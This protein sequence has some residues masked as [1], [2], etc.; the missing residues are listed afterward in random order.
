VSAFEVDEVASDESA[1][2]DAAGDA[3]IESPLVVVGNAV[4]MVVAC[5]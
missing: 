3:A 5:R 4:D 2:V 1:A